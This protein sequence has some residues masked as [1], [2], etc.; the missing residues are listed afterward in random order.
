MQV[1]DIMSPGPDALSPGMPVR[2]LE[3]RL[4][5]HQVS[6]FPVLEEGKLV[7]IVTRSD[8]VRVLELE[9]TIDDQLGEGV[10]GPD[11]A[12]SRGARI[13]A[14]LEAMTVGDVMVRSVLSVSPDTPVADAARTMV[15]ARVHRLPVVGE[16][17]LVG[18]VTSLD[19]ARAIA[20]GRLP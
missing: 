10:T 3:E 1:R 6:G 18:L 11:S 13:G 8:L 2:E 17:G 5:S 14:R 4:V 19:L 7:G 15:E 12:R 9:H 16:G 20:D